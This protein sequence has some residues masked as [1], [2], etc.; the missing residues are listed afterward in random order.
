MN[1]TPSPGESRGGAMVTQVTEGTGKEPEHTHPPVTHSHDH[2]HVSH[3][4]SGGLG[5]D[6]EHRA[7]WH[8]HAH[9]HNAL[10]HSHDFSRAD[11]EAHHDK[12]AHIHD[13]AAPTESPA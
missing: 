13:H 10:T 9:N 6:F 11:E 5:D 3:H 8:T 1:A 2:W 4:H 12:E 7:Y